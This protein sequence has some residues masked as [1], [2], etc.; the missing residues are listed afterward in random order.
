M[1]LFNDCEYKTYNEL[2]TNLY[3]CSNHKDLNTILNTYISKL[4]PADSSIFLLYENDGI[5]AKS[6]YIINLEEK[7]FTDYLNYYQNFDLYKSIIH[8]KN[9]PPVVNRVSDYLDYN[10]W[11]KNE[12]RVDFLKPQK[13]YHICCMEILDKNKIL[14]SLS[15]HRNK[16]HQDFTDKELYI[17]KLLAPVIKTIY[18]SIQTNFPR[19]ILNDKLTTRE[20]QILPLLT[21]N[22]STM[23]LSS[24]VGISKNTIK[25]HIRNILRKT[26]CASRFELVIKMQNI[27]KGDFS[28]EQSTD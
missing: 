28:D 24:Y 4:V 25:T 13:I 2:I 10:R 1:F 12:H 17:L 6:S 21:K 5:T 27:K 9:K 23:E 20:K 7:R 26:D 19:I 14:A 11:E 8:L 22:Y 15:L 3:N 16:K 18:Q